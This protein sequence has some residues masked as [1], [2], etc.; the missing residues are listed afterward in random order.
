MSIHSVS[1][2]TIG[3]FTD[4]IARFH[5]HAYLELLGTVDQIKIAELLVTDAITEV[6]LLPFYTFFLASTP[7]FTK[8]ITFQLS[9]S[10]ISI[11][12]CL[13]VAISTHLLIYGSIW[14]VF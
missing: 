1:G 8:I 6:N 14:V 10:D 5:C 3:I 13:E 9:T 12:L 7:W 4:A 2:A 11:S